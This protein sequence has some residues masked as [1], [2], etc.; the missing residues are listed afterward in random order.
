MPLLNNFIPLPSAPYS[1]S[2][3][4][5]MLVGFIL[6]SLT[7]PVDRLVDL[8][9]RPPIYPKQSPLTA[10]RT[11][12]GLARLRDEQKRVNWG[13]RGGRGRPLPGIHDALPVLAAAGSSESLARCP[14]PL[15]RSSAAR[16]WSLASPL[17]YVL[18]T[19]LWKL[20]FKPAENP[21]P[22][23]SAPSAA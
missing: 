23:P 6:R 19:K 8:T 22:A 5:L 14:G 1:L 18:G 2:V 4:I 17:G 12:L 15:A 7:T 13:P 10:W 3:L 9:V 16:R 21:P 20:D 11:L